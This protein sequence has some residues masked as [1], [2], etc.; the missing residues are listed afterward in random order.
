[1]IGFLVMLITLTARRS[2]KALS[3]HAL[4]L[5]QCEAWAEITGMK[6]ELIGEE[7]LHLSAAGNREF[8]QGCRDAGEITRLL[9]QRQRAGGND[10]LA[11]SSVD[12]ALALPPIAD[13]GPVGI[14]QARVAI[15]DLWEQYFE[16][17]V[18]ACRDASAAAPGRQLPLR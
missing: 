12:S 13:G 2:V 10:L 3:S 8:L 17:R 16:T 15:S 14:D 5:V 6:P 1:M 4:A 9:E 18:I 11:V 7:V